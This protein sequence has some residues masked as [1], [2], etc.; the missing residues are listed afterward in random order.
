[1]S[2][3]CSIVSSGDLWRPRPFI[4]TLCENEAQ[5]G[6]GVHPKSLRGLLARLRG[7][8]VS[9]DLG[10]SPPTQTLL[11]AHFCLRFICLPGNIP[12]NVPLGKGRDYQEGAVSGDVERPR[13]GGLRAGLAS[14]T[15]SPPQSRAC[16][17]DGPSGDLGDRCGPEPAWGP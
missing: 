9:L 8:L 16:R 10:W 2:H 13:R 6:Q 15:P 14:K 11:G 4:Y 12:G 1:M 7:N 17:S 3:S 5:R